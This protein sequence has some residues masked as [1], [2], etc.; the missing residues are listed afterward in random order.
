LALLLGGIGALVFHSM[1]IREDI[2]VSERYRFQALLLA[3]ELL[4]T[5]D[6]LTRMAR[7]YVI[8]GNPIY[9]RYFLEILNIR[10]GVI[11]R[12]LN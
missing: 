11:A 9:K 7:S 8:T 12:P 1:G 10:K 5:S 4:H 2:N 3:D 6:D